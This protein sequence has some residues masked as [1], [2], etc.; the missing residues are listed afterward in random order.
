MTEMAYMYQ[1]MPL[2]CRSLRKLGNQVDLCLESPGLSHG[3]R[4]RMM[5]AVGN[6]LLPRRVDLVLRENLP[7]EVDAHGQRVGR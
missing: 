3:D 6:L 5:A 7:A 4:L 1:S 2:A